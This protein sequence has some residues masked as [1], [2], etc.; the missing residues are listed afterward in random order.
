MACKLLVR[1]FFFEPEVLTTSTRISFSRSP[2]ACYNL[3]ADMANYPSFIPWILGSEVVD[4]GGNIKECTLD[5]GYPPYRQSYLSKVTLNY[6][7]KIVSLS[8][9]NKVFELLE[10]TWEFDVDPSELNQPGDE[11]LLTKCISN[12]SAKFKFR[13]AVYQAFSSVIIDHLQ[14]KTIEAFVE[15]SKTLPESK[16]L[17]NKLTKEIKPFQ[18]N[19]N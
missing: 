10:S 12:Y 18:L 6:P 8:N 13:S 16:C 19:K 11:I 3:V 4:V 9:N 17:Y 2:S 7:V 5:V 1:R 15:K 14:V